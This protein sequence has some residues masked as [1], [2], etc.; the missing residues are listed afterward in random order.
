[1]FVCLVSGLALIAVGCTSPPPLGEVEGVVRVGGKPLADV[2]VTFLPD[3]DQDHRGERAA[4]KTDAEGRYRLRREQGQNGTMIGVYRVVI[5]DLAIY[6][7]P[8]TSD[9]T[10]LAKPPVRFSPQLAAPL[11]T[12]LRREVK[13]GAQ[14]IDFDLD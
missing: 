14:T 9:G 11:Q 8:R 10:L 2:L 12:P 4:G 1:L 5:E 6:S 3:T 13:A 7:A